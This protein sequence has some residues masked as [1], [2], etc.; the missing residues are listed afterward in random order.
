ME[1][2][3]NEKT[4][5]DDGQ[6]VAHQ[7]SS[8]V[9]KHGKSNRPITLNLVLRITFLLGFV[10]FALL[11][12]NEVIITPYRINH[13]IAKTNRL[14]QQEER[15]TGPVTETATPMIS[16]PI[17]RHEKDA[18]TA[19]NLEEELQPNDPTRDEKGRLLQFKD[20]LA[21]NEDVK[22]WITIP[23]TNIDYVVLQ[24]SNHDP[25]YYLSHDIEKHELKAGSIFLDSK[26]SV[27]Q[28]SKNLTIHGHNMTSTDN[29]F[30]YITKF[31]ELDYYKKRPILTFDTIKQTGQWKIFSIFITNGGSQKEEFFNYTKS[32]FRD[33]GDFLNFIY[34]LRSRSL[35]LI[36]TVDVNENDQ[37]LTLSTCSYEVKNYRTVIVARRLREGEEAMVDVDTVTIN[38]AP[39]Y[40]ES[41]YHRYGGK[42]PELAATF[43]EALNNGKIHWYLLPQ[44][45]VQ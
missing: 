31:K 28:A 38:P 7:E 45:T 6:N 27:E 5:K 24:S 21:V 3:N 15:V 16:S 30:H 2:E 20:L 25:E 1:A 8:S 10:L 34:Q 43:E 36:D 33:D 4:K 39:L 11:F 40:P 29:M 23:A 12:L 22:G 17:D 32:D 18:A 13:S 19:T 26:C 41:Y 37:L 35:F 42:A 9:T 44:E 14:Y